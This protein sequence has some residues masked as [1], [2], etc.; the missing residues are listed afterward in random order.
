MFP[1]ATKELYF[2]LTSFISSIDVHRAIFF[3]RQFIKKQGGVTRAHEK[4]NIRKI[5]RQRVPVKRGELISCGYDI[6][7]KIDKRQFL[8]I[9]FIGDTGIGLGPT[10][11]FYDNIADEFKTWSLTVEEVKMKDHLGNV[12]GSLDF[13][14]WRNTQDNLLFPSPVSTREFSKESQQKIFEVF[15]L[16]GTIVAKAMTDDRQIDLPISPLFW[17][18]CLGSQLSIFDYE[19]LDE[20]VFK[21]LAFL[22]VI[23]N[24]VEELD[25]Q[26]L[27]AEAKK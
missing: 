20:K 4:D 25:K 19:K 11:E 6:V 27:E 12:T 21:Q 5:A 24:R 23:A 9:E 13:K 15:R 1:F 8:E 3:L 22:Q 10:L 17:K 16:C 14:M 2:K 7:K 26:S 18:L